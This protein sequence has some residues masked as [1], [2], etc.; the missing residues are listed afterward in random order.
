MNDTNPPSGAHVAAE[1][2]IPM[3]V[4]PRLLGG[5]AAVRQVEARRRM[6]ERVIESH[7]LDRSVGVKALHALNAE[8]RRLALGGRIVP[9]DMLDAIATLE[10]ALG[11]NATT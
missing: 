10:R 3:P 8:A 4:L 1:E 11:Q 2:I 6:A 7:C 9:A 5:R